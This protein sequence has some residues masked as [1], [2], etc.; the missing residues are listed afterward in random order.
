[1]TSKDLH[2]NQLFWVTL[3]K[4]IQDSWTNLSNLIGIVNEHSEQLPFELQAVVF[5]GVGKFALTYLQARDEEHD[6][7]ESYNKALM[8]VHSD[9]RIQQLQQNAAIHMVDTKTN[10]LGLE[11]M[12]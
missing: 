5:G 9:R 4:L 10:S 1:M 6:I 3:D 2:E 8:A 7:I 12:E 11:G